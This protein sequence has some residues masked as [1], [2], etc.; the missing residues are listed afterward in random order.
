MLA[1][2]HQ[3]QFNL[4]LDVFDVD[5]AAAVLVARHGR[6]HGIGHVR[7]ALADARA[8][9]RRAAFHG[10]EGLGDGDVDLL[11]FETGDLAVAA[12]HAHA[13]GGGALQFSAAGRNGGVVERRL[14]P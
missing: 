2:A 6:D 7:H 14:R 5:G 8:G 12:D 1:G 4:V 3:G 10:E 11:G 9:G 13:T